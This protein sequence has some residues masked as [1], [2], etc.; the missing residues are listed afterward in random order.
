MFNLFVLSTRQYDDIYSP[1]EKLRMK[2]RGEYPK[3]PARVP[4]AKVKALYRET[5]TLREF[6]IKGKTIMAYSC[7][8]AIKRFNHQNKK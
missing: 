6:N 7:K 3:K 1:D 2:P 8:D 4:A 5:K